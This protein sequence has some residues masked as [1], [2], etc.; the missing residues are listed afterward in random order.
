MLLGCLDIHRRD[1]HSLVGIVLRSL[2]VSFLKVF[3]VTVVSSSV[4][5]SLVVVF[6][7]FGEVI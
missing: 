3:R 4:I 6:S 2:I 7:S 5:L 1:K